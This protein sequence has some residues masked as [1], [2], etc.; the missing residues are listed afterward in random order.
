MKRRHREGD[1]PDEAAEPALQLVG[2][3][4][5]FLDVLLGLQQRLGADDGR[6]VRS[7]VAAALN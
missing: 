4:F 2:G 3:A 5:F 1:Q 7:H 6:L